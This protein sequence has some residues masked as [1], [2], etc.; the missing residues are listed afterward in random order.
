MKESEDFEGRLVI[1]LIRWVGGRGHLSKL[2]GKWPEK[3]CD[4]F[5]F[6]TWDNMEVLIKR[7]EQ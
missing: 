2:A 4:L 6:P 5:F 1:G 7:P 3:D